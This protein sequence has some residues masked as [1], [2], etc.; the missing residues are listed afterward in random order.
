MMR[1]AFAGF[2]Q[3]CSPEAFG[4]SHWRTVLATD[5][6]DLKEVGLAYRRALKRNHPD[7]GG[8][9]DDFHRVQVA[10]DQARAELSSFNTGTAPNDTVN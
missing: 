5:S 1:A 10:M 6:Y 7:H 2:A 9:T 8:N 4:R 3:L